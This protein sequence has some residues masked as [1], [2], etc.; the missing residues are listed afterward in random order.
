MALFVTIK[1]LK[2]LKYRKAIWNENSGIYTFKLK[3]KI[4]EIMSLF[5]MQM[6]TDR[7]LL[8]FEH[9]QRFYSIVYRILK[10]FC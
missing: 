6:A 4:P 10:Y 1:T 7:I 2:S 5:T 3:F 8:F 9:R